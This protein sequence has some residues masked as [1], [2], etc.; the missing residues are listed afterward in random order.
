[1]ALQ[2]FLLLAGL[3]LGALNP[4]STGPSRSVVTSSVSSIPS[5]T[6]VVSRPSVTRVVSVPSVQRQTQVSQTRVTSVQRTSSTRQTV[7]W[8]MPV[9]RFNAFPSYSS[10][11]I[12][13]INSG[14]PAFYNP[15]GAVLNLTRYFQRPADLSSSWAGRYFRNAQKYAPVSGTRFSGC[16]GE[17]LPV[18]AAGR[19]FNNPCLAGLASVSVVAAGNCASSASINP[20]TTANIPVTPDESLPVTSTSSTS[21]ST[22]PTGT[23]TTTDFPTPGP[24]DQT[25][26]DSNGYPTDQTFTD[27]EEVPI[28]GGFDTTNTSSEAPIGTGPDVIGSTRY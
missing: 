10:Y 8:R 1:M 6:R 16:G 12:I 27:Y 25:Y 11:F 3:A 18:C 22:T 28:D 17:V 20:I 21:T 13:R 26:P 9:I 4:I 5:I 23:T 14:A 15:A 2:E 24:T 19:T 7:V